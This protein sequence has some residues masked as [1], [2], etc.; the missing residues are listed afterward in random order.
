MSNPTTA[1]QAHPRTR[2]RPRPNR[3]GGNAILEMALVMPM[4]MFL[5]LGM[6]EFGQ[7]FYIHNAFQQAAR[8]ALRASIMPNAQ[9]ADP[10]TAA[11][12]TLAAAGITFQSSW[13]NI[14]D[15]TP[16]GWGGSPVGTVT[17]VST[18]PAG[19]AITLTITTTYGS[20]P[21][22][23]RPLYAVSG[24]YGIPSGRTMAGSSSGLKE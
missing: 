18:V 24:G 7:F 17:D 13:M 22:A 3:R 11:R 9:Q 21:G 6:V 15:I 23:V 5:A 19:H 20:L 1:V 14:Q 16:L 4:L 2:E 10:T 8:D 12:R